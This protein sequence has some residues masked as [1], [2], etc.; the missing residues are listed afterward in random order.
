MYFLYIYNIDLTDKVRQR[1]VNE[2]E[3]KKE[4][5]NYFIQYFGK[6]ENEK[7][8]KKMRKKNEKKW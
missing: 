1:K 2:K 4:R 5:K 6:R 8:I 3:G 7:F